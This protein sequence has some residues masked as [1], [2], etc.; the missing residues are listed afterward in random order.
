VKYLVLIKIKDM[1]E[2]SFTKCTF[3]PTKLVV[4]LSFWLE[5]TKIKLDHWKLETPQIEIEATISLPT[6]P[7]LPS[8]LVLNSQSIS[9]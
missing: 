9:K 1:V 6:N 5:F 8:D 4:D 3:Q 7:N 2:T